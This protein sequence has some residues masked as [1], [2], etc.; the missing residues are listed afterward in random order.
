MKKLLLV[1]CLSIGLA[2]AS[3]AQPTSAPP[4]DPQ[5]RA[6]GLQK[7]LKLS[8]D[9]TS[10]IAA[11]YQDSSEKF[12]QIKKKEHGDTNKMLVDVAPLRKATVAKIKALLTTK[13]AEKY[14]TLISENKASGLQGGW[15]GGWS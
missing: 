15:S 3:F 2:T 6:K 1:C 7:E 4:S 9:Q 13:Q 12:D 10:K 8:D 14:N 11:I 5:Q